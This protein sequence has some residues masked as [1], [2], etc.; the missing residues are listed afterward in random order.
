MLAAVIPPTGLVAWYRAEGD[1]R[2]GAYGNH[3]I[4]GEG[5]NVEAGKVGQAFR[6]DEVEDHVEAPPD[7]KQN[8]GQ[9]ITIEAWVYPDTLDHGRPIVQKRSA[10]NVGGYTLETT[11][12]SV[13]GE[14]ANGLQFVLWLGSAANQARLVTP[15]DA[16]TEDVWQH[17]AATYDGAAMKIYVNGVEVASQAASGTIAATNDPLAIGRNAVIPSF[18]W[19][20]LLD[21]VSLY[22]RALS[23][24]EIQAIVAA[25]S[26][27]KDPGAVVF[28]AD[29]DQPT[30]ST[31]YEADFEGAV[32]AEWSSTTTD[33]TPT[34]NRRFL[35]QFG[36]DAVTL[37]IP[38]AA[39]PAGTTVF[40]LDFDLFVIRTWD[41]NH[42]GS[43]SGP[44]R[45]SLSVNGQSLLDTS[46][47]NNHPNSGLAGQAFPSQFGGG[48]FAP[49]TGAAEINTLGFTFPG[50]D[51]MDSVYHLEPTIPYSGGDL[52]L[53]FTGLLTTPGEDE[54]WGLDNVQLT[55]LTAGAQFS[56]VTTTAEV[57]GFAVHGFSDNLLRND[58]LSA[59]PTR[60][61]LTDLPPHEAIDLRFLLAV[62]DSWDG[63]Q[64]FSHQFFAPDRFNVAVDG[65]V[66]FSETFVNALSAGNV[67]SYVAPPGVELVRYQQRGFNPDNSDYLDSAY[68]LGLDSAFQNIPHTA[69][70]L[71]VE[72]S[73]G[74]AGY[75]GGFNESWGIDNVEVVLRGAEP[76]GCEPAIADL[77]VTIEDAPDPI[78]LGE[79]VTYT[80]TATNHGPA[81]A[82]G[83]IV[84]SHGPAGQQFNSVTIPVGALASGASST[85]QLSFTPA[86]IGS[87][88]VTANVTASQDDP[89]D[90]NNSFTATT[91]V[92]P[93]L[94]FELAQAQFEVREG[95]PF[96]VLTV[97]RIGDLTSGASVEFATID[98][99]AGQRGIRTGLS[100]VDDF[101]TTSGTLFFRSR[102]DRA[103][104][105]IP[106]RDDLSLE[107][108]ETFRVVLSNPSA[109]AELGAIS[110]AEVVIHD[111]DP[112]LSFV[113]SST[114]RSESI[115]GRGSIEVRLNPASNQTVTVGYAAVSGTATAG[116]DFNVVGRTLTFRPGETR[117]FIQ[118]SNVNDTLFEGNE[119][120]FIELSSPT[121]A[122]LGAT[123]R[124]RLTIVD[125]DPVPLPPD[126]GATLDAALAI[127]L[128]TLPRQSFRHFV[129]RTSGGISDIDMFRAHLDAGE[130]IVLDVDPEGTPGLFPGIANSTLTVFGSDGVTP[131]I[132]QLATANR[133][134]E[135]DTGAV[136]NNAALLFRAPASG[137]YY[138]QLQTNVNG[139][140][141]YRLH[142]HRLGVSENVPSPELLNV[143]GAM[144]AWYDAAG[145][146]IGI[147]GP[148]GY[149]FTLAGPWQQQ[150]AR[151]RRTG[152]LSQTLTLPAGSQFTLASP[153]G[154]V[155]PLIANGPIVIKTKAGRFG[156]VVG[157]VTAKAIKF[158]VA[159]DIVPI[160]ALF[161]DVFGPGFVSVGVLAGEWRISLGGEAYNL[162]GTPIE[163]TDHVPQLLPG[164]PYLRRFGGSTLDVLV[165]GVGLN[166]LQE[167]VHL[168]VDPADPLIYVRLAE[169][170]TEGNQPTVAVSKHGLLH[171]TPPDP[172]TTELAASELFGHIFAAVDI[173][174][175][176]KQIPGSGSSDFRFTV[177]GDV[178]VNLDAD[179]D[180]TFLGGVGDVDEVFN[181]LQ[182]DVDVLRD[183]LND[184]QLG[185]SGDLALDFDT[186]GLDLRLG[187]GSLILNG[188][189][190]SIWLRTSQTEPDFLAGTPLGWMGLGVQ[191]VTEAFVN[192]DGQF[193]LSTTTTS[194]QAGTELEYE[195]RISHE[196]IGARVTGRGEWSATIDFGAGTVSGKAIAELEGNIRIV[197]DDDGDPHV[198]GSITAKGRLRA[199]G[200]T[201]FDG[202]IE[203]S[204]KS[205]GFRFRFPRGV[206]N[207]DLDLF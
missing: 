201:L 196:G 185:A 76:C 159:L 118:F 99:T 56:G 124:H 160:N 89:D 91:Q 138:F 141:G 182:G 117:K 17:V 69:S 62:I 72:W 173:A 164:V 189:D 119:V 48:Q 156:D 176:V 104:I 77:A 127:D 71:T 20:G 112:T 172:P 67:Q 126:P 130:A 203:A 24:A 94:K 11:H 163:R 170:T 195:I 188:L 136:T 54:S 26:A 65:D 52:A 34:G 8:P 154:V 33:A 191:A 95:E 184:V 14:P 73:A 167:P 46:F 202:S 134:A 16:L 79:S 111:N 28:R 42:N 204:V 96:A 85:H 109:G 35:G 10:G 53:T 121:N 92:I 175:R 75:E 80:V 97:R 6:F 199:S 152:L 171:Y 150:A 169:Q 59:A 87:F 139:L 4:G 102:S 27:G 192:W 158:P 161:T 82:T 21:E 110:S 38:A 206:G 198:S 23:P 68:N 122:F 84:V 155:V 197:I 162:L 115:T 70:T 37:T 193:L 120:G 125:N 113:S 98:G 153:E 66:I 101:T 49:H 131:D 1:A 186:F 13:A 58:T 146:K 22:N 40:K 179:R 140:F 174:L 205:R 132:R 147:T 200:R 41:G 3:A 7:A 44:D 5:T 9:Q 45:W 78:A 15:A 166:V 103:T 64:Q 151:D 100:R 168:I 143:A 142:F 81:D 60:L 190:E 29:F 43:G 108:D 145:G 114:Q 90:S 180:G 50:V 74:G 181:L 31:V 137:D 177:D 157:E 63:D 57:Q 106:I 30:V 178:L 194:R 19:D 187:K 93:R 32:G 123:T 88:S 144:F 128:A 12:S 83:V 107:Q 183:M 105:Q 2:D 47:S 61:T 148:T 39:I 86:A 18:T 165:G 51:V 116:T 207:L 55:A 133:S 149:G 129:V 25:D 135:P 36:N